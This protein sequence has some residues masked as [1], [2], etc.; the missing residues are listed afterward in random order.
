MLRLAR[1][2]QLRNWRCFS[3]G[4]IRRPT[5]AQVRDMPLDVS[6]LQGESLVVL[7]ENGCQAACQERLTREV[8]RVEGIEWEDADIKVQQI[9]KDNAS[10]QALQSVPHKI[11]LATALISGVAS[12]PMCFH[13]P[14]VEWMNKHL[15]TA[16]V[17]EPRDL[18]TFW[19]VGAWSWNWMEPV[20][21]TAS[22]V[23]L[24]L[25]FSRS[26]MVKLDMKPFTLKMRS[27]RADKLARSYPQYN[28]DILRDFSKAE[29]Y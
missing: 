12:I 29:R 3:T 8:M 20:L 13:L 19:E 23:L 25:Q 11:G 21:G 28:K 26:I 24:T 17:P 22:F 4:S 7:A 2:P 10:L 15:V 9:A 27:L 16:D 14:T 6:E 1:H 5:L 18:E